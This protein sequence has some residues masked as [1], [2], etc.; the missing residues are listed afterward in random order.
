MIYF[1]ILS[2]RQYGHCQR[3]IYL[4]EYKAEGCARVYSIMDGVPRDVRLCTALCTVFVVLYTLVQ[5][6]RRVVATS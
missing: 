6:Q 3:M 1:Y 4:G 2:C 5:P